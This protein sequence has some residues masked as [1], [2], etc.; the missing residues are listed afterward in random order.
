[1]SGTYHSSST[2]G[3]QLSIAHLDEKGNASKSKANSI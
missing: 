1:M 3:Y 2:Y